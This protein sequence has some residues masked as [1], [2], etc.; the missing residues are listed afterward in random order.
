MIWGCFCLGLVF[1]CFFVGGGGVFLGETAYTD[2]R[3]N[4]FEGGKTIHHQAS[5]A[6]SHPVRS[7]K[8]KG[9]NEDTIKGVGSDLGA[10]RFHPMT[11]L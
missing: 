5:S 8:V 7:C 6:S 4:K 3:P 9:R 10:P 2:S 11:M 1:F